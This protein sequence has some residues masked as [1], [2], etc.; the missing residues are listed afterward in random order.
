[1][2]LEFSIRGMH[3]ASCSSR[4]ERALQDMP[5]VESAT[6][7]LA[8]NTAQVRLRNGADAKAI[9]QAVLDAVAQL[10]FSA[11]ALGV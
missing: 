3:C 8:A 11:E 1:M 2:V 10:G 6:V 4:V 5:Q 7:S 9:R